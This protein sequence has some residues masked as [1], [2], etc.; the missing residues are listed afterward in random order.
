[1]HSGLRIGR[2]ISVLSL[3]SFSDTSLGIC[4]KPQTNED[5]SSR[6]EIRFGKN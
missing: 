4:T 3:E 1:M 5:S 6:S 2:A